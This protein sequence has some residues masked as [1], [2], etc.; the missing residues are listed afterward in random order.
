MP[1]MGSGR[2]H[3]NPVDQFFPGDQFPEYSFSRRRATD[4]ASANEQHA[5]NHLSLL[6]R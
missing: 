5:D 1:S 3:I 4:I 2:R 6:S